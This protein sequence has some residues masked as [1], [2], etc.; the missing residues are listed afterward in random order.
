[1]NVFLW[2]LQLALAF[3]TFAG[4]AYKVFMFDA[5]AG[6]PAMSALSRGGWGAVGVFEMLCALLLVLPAALKWMP[7]LTPVGAAVLAVESLALAALYGRHSLQFTATNPMV[8]VLI[9]GLLAAFVAY[10]RFALVPRV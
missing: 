1:M 6:D 2:I 3:Q 5:I 7:A 4:G 9:G 8:Y 10:G